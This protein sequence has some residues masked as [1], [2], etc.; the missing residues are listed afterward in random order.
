[1]SS[2]KK[3]VAA[4]VSDIEEVELTEEVAAIGESGTTLE[5]ASPL[6]MISSFCNQN[7]NLVTF[8]DTGSP[9]S[10]VKYSVYSRFY[11]DS[12]YKVRPSVINLKNLCDQSLE[13]LGTVKVSL[14]IDL[15][16]GSSFAIDLFVMSNATLETDIILG[17]EFLHKQKL[18][19]VYK[20][21]DKPSLSKTN[22]FTVLPHS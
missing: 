16:S 6:I 3:A 5:V 22:L 14:T 10:F 17:R 7:C 8:V 1:M 9:V 18:T 4:V 21:E 15:L 11:T 20:P 2:S 19:L 12:K 13:L